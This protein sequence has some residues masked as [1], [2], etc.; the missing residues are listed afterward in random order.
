[1]NNKKEL[2]KIALA[3]RPNVG[4]STIFNIFAKK[5]VAIEFSKP[6]TTR[7][8][9]EKIVE[10]GERQVLLVDTGGFEFESKDPLYT[11][12]G[13]KAKKVIKEADLVLFIVEKDN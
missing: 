1:M 11:L 3:G 5:R 2:Y 8:P 6:G 4:K 12:I 13:E 10:I 9:I 7:D